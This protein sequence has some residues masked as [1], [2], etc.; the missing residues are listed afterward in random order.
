MDPERAINVLLAHPVLTPDTHAIV[1]ALL[2]HA[3]NPPALSLAI[4]QRTIDHA[5][6]A[7]VE[8][9]QPPLTVNKQSLEAYLRHISHACHADPRVDYCLAVGLKDEI[10]AWNCDFLL[11]GEHPEL[12]NATSS[13]QLKEME[14]LC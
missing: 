4:I 10:N 12:E 5:L 2:T 8:E 7:A 3:L 9:F 6:R 1:H 14:L 13:I 11:Y